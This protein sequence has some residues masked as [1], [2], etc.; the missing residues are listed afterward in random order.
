M[1]INSV[2]VLRKKASETIDE[3]MGGVSRTKRR[4]DLNASHV[5]VVVIVSKMVWNM[6]KANKCLSDQSPHPT[7]VI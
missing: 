2:Q 5:W 3:M 1:K 7:R 4:R 6:T